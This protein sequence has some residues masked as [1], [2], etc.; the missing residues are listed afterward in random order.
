MWEERWSRSKNRA[1]FLNL[2]TKESQWERPEGVEIKD[3]PKMEGPQQIRASHLLVKHSGS[4]RPSSWKQENITRSKEEAVETIKSIKINKNSEK[5]LNK[6]KW[7][8]MF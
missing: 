8:L 4:R 2:E 1:Y 6:R 3:M 7:N 5:E